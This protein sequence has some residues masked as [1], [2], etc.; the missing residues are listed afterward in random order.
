MIRTDDI[1]AVRRLPVFATMASDSFDTLVTASFMQRFPRET[2]LLEEGQ[3]ADTLCV[4]VEGRVEMSSTHA[5]RRTTVAVFE[6]V[7]AFILAAVVR[8]Q[9]NLM[10]ARTLETSR[11]LIIPATVIQDLIG[12]DAAFASAM[13]DELARGFRT[14]VKTVKDQK[15]RP[16][17]ERIANY[18]LRLRAEHGDAD[19]FHLT[20][21]K[22]TLA[23][24]LGMTRE[25]LSRSLSTIRDHGAVVRGKE[26]AITDLDALHA[27]AQPNVLIDDPRS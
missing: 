9:V 15:L 2:V 17:N 4:I 26:V 16:A 13:I 23:S 19:R 24:L 27:L 3:P 25:N 18:L 10:S 11:V 1:E 22:A 20:L 14:M 6:P 12:A 7:T 5:G 21:D 8:D